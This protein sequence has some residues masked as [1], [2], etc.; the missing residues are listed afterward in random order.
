M[1]RLGKYHY[2]PVRKF[3]YLE[4]QEIRLEPKMAEVLDYLLQHP[5]RYVPLQE[6]HDNVWSGRIVTDTAVRRVISRLRAQLE[7]NV[8]Q[9][10]ILQSLPKRGYRLSFEPYELPLDLP[11]LDSISGGLSVVE[12]APRSLSHLI[13]FTRIR[14]ML[15]LLVLV[16]LGAWLFVIERHSTDSAAVLSHTQS[17]QLPVNARV[18]ALSSDGVKLLYQL[19]RGMERKHDI[20]IYYPKTHSSQLIAADSQ[21]VSYG[22]F[23][24]HDQALLLSFRDL[25]SN[26]GRLELWQLNSDA[27]LTQKRVLLSQLESAI[28][29]V[30]LPEQNAALVS[31][32]YPDKPDQ[33]IY[34]RLQ[35]QAD[36]AAR[37]EPFLD[38]S[39][40]YR[41]D[42]V[43]S[44]SPN[45][46]L[47]AYQRNSRPESDSEIQIVSMQERRL[48]QR[49]PYA[50]T[51]HDTMWL[52]DDVLLVLGDIQLKAYRVSTRTW[53]TILQ[54]QSDAM[55][56][57]VKSGPDILLVE[58]HASERRLVELDLS[59]DKPLYSMVQ[60]PADYQQWRYRHRYPDQTL[61][62]RRT[63]QGFQL[64]V[65]HPEQPLTLLQTEAE[66][67]IADQAADGRLLL[68][69]GKRLALFNPSTNENLYVTN[70]Q[71]F[72][73]NALFMHQDTG[74]LY[75]H[76]SGGQWLIQHFDL[77]KRLHQTV[78]TGYRSIKASQDGYILSDVNG[79]LFH[80]DKQLQQITALPVQVITLDVESWASVDGAIYWLTETPD[81]L[82]LRRYN[83]KTQ[84]A[85][86]IPVAADI[87][88]LWLDVRADG[89]RLMLESTLTYQSRLQTVTA[90]ITEKLR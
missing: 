13:G 79:H 28:Y 24:E 75:S 83:L 42:S 40:Y 66:M 56:R 76:F 85:E 59:V 9:P 57:L 6:L 37:L 10:H 62:V 8:E 88:F 89:R 82:A 18:I 29:P 45:G 34:H 26:T 27:V 47:F 31:V 61:A 72:T 49:L 22:A 86:T 3:L 73:E 11:V 78:L 65:W 53:T 19:K 67:R 33:H 54:N 21:F 20:F 43:G 14:R 63:Q 71:L 77:S 50:D 30:A 52:D 87:A 64:D 84:H 46:R 38:S 60:R 15:L 1:F 5:E 2:C 16:V 35:W 48:I 36:G 17:I 51:V 70:E 58:R 80:A 12:P 25:A 90:D 39:S 44:L 74:I 68:K 7:D 32:G 23:V 81:G 55:R 69:I 4:Q 41:V